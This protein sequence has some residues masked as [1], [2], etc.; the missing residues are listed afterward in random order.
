MKFLIKIVLIGLVLSLPLFA[1]SVATLTGM[2][3]NVSI[4]NS[5][6]TSHATLGAKLEEK[7]NVITADKSKAQLIFADETIVTIGKN[8]DFSI[9]TYLYET[10]KEPRVEFGLLKGAMS[11]ITGKI[12]KIAPEK[13]VVRTKTATIGIRGTNF[14]ILALED[15]SQQV[16][17][18]YGAISVMISSELNIVQQGYYANIS[19]SGV[20][21]VRA[22][23]SSD[24]SEMK[25]DNFGKH[26]PLKGDISQHGMEIQSS[27]VLDTT[28]EKVDD[29]V[30]INVTE[31]MQDV[32]QQTETLEEQHH[33]SDYQ[34][35]DYQLLY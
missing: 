29:A 17:C 27:V 22:F 18:T 7:D 28:I 11:T 19:P 24:L 31:D 34:S 14:T 16:Y 25:T 35:S 23:S 12:G 13:F 8:S 9:K 32:V 6:G 3:G 1:S 21:N 26:E 10:S 2:K 33:P 30:I 20:V 4:K 15:G 5:V